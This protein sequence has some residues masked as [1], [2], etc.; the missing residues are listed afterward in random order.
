M[1]KPDKEILGQ[2]KKFTTAIILNADIT[3][4]SRE[5]LIADVFEAM[6]TIARLPLS[7]TDIKR[8]SANVNYFEDIRKR[9]LS[10][11]SSEDI[12]L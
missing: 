4:F 8:G 9:R 6:Q 3:Q 7:S 2:W 5:Q 11:K 1:D 10:L 12:N